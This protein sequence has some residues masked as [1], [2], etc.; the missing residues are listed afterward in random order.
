MSRQPIQIT[1][2]GNRVQI[3]G[4]VG[5]A[6]FRKLLA[7]A[8]NL[9]TRRGYQDVVLDFSE[10]GAVY[11]GPMLAMCAEAARLRLAN[12]E[13]DL[14]LPKSVR[15]ANLFRNSGWAHFLS[16]HAHAPSTFR[17]YRHVPVIH[18]SSPAEQQTA[19]NELMDA[20]LSSMESLEREDLAAIEW[21]VNEVTDNVLVHSQSQVGGFVQL[22]N[23]SAK[24]RVEFVVSDAGVGI[25][26]TLRSGHPEL[27][28]D[29]LALEHAIREGVTRDIR[30]GQGN[31]LY[32]SFQVAQQSHGYFHIHSGFARLD[33]DS[34]QMRIRGEDVPF[35]GSLVVACMDVSNPSALGQ[36]LKF[37]GQV[38]EGYDY[39]EQRYE[40]PQGDDLLFILR[41]EA[42]SF[43]SRVAGQPVRIKLRNLARMN[44]DR[45]I[46]VDFAD[47]ALVSSSFA[48][49]VIAKLFVE[50]G[51]MAFLRSI[52]LTN[53]SPTVQALIDRAI[54]QRSRT[55]A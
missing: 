14:V 4:D 27:V 33:Y 31:G 16:P 8:H 13:F 28:T 22:T 36:A 12:I 24:R 3:R 11:P 52:A 21:S 54:L 1:T 46:L 6:G 34:D 43:G 51:P 5:L 42:S 17:G 9:V 47:V 41:D 45:R 20:V 49:E 37:R 38:H 32:G 53:V 50:L 7:T 48:D 23:Y 35:H 55:G 30:I 2:T 19:V 15:L 44:L 29:M 26:T 25:P 10:C 39:L 18:Y 40:Q